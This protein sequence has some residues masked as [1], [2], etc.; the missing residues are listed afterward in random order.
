[1]AFETDLIRRYSGAF[2]KEDCARIIDGIKFFDQNHLLFY[3]KEKLT[4]EDHKTVNISHD[5]NFSAS[6]RIAEEIFPKIKPCVDEYLQA[7][8]V[9]GMRKFLLH[10]L[11]LKEIPSG[12]GFHAWH[13]EN[14]ALDVAARQFVVQIYLNDDFDGGETE[15]LYQQRREVAVAGDVLIFPASFTHTHRGN[16]PL[17]G[18]KYIATSWGMIQQ[19]DSN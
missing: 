12:G 9:L 18:T 19:D 7:F 11:K 16:P 10:D 1:M 15:F 17:G 8:N 2:S 3:D 6:S 13:Y 5:Y 4:R 14:G